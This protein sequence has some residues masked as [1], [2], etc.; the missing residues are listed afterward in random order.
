MFIYPAR[1][2]WDLG[3]GQVSGTD[4]AEWSGRDVPFFA[5]F[6][7]RFC[8]EGKVSLFFS[9]VRWWALS[10]FADSTFDLDVKGFYIAWR[11]VGCMDSV[12]F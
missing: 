4:S 12:M 11:R 9:G 8:V 3:L 2:D 10:F 5:G 6:G 1:L 7:C